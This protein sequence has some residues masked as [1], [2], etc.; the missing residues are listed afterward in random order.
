MLGARDLISGERL[1]DL[2]G[3]AATSHQRAVDTGKGSWG[4]VLSRKEDS[5]SHDV[6]LG[7]HLDLGRVVALERFVVG[8]GVLSVLQTSIVLV[9]IGMDTDTVSQVHR[10]MDEAIVVVGVVYLRCVN[11]LAVDSNQNILPDLL[12]PPFDGTDVRETNESLKALDGDQREAQ[13]A[14]KPLMRLATDEIA[15]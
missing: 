1:H 8:F 13:L 7:H 6:V 14:D 4:G 5:A 2:G 11:V 15:L 12:L 3:L 9:G 10:A